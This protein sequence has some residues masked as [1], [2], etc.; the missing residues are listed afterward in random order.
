MLKRKYYYSGFWGADELELKD[1]PSALALF[2]MVKCIGPN[3]SL[4]SYIYCCKHFRKV[5]IKAMSKEA[6]NS[7]PAFKARQ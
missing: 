4:V 7:E 5:H 3:L 2:N 6:L 1:V